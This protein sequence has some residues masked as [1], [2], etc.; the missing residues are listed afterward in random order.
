MILRST[1][2]AIRGATPTSRTERAWLTALNAF[3]QNGA[4]VLVG[5]V[6]TPIV[7][8]LLGS[9]LYGNWLIIVQMAGYLLLADLN[10][11]T[12]LKLTLAT[13]QHLEDQDTKRRQIGASLVVGLINLPLYLIGGIALIWAAPF[14][15]RDSSGDI[16]PMRCALGLL[17]LNGYLSN[18]LGAPGVVLRGMNLDFK[19]MGLKAGLLIG[20]GL[21][22]I[23]VVKA[24]LG[25]PGLA[26]NRIVSAA[27]M[28]GLLCVVARRALPWFGTS[29]PKFREVRNLLGLSLWLELYSLAGLLNQSSDL[30]LIGWVLGP[31][32]AALFSLTRSLPRMASQP[33]NMLL[34]S[35]N[36]GL[37]DLYGRGE[38]E[39]IREVRLQIHSAAI[40]LLTVVSCVA[41]ALNPAFVHRWVGADK[42]AG[43]VVNMLLVLLAAQ[44]T[45]GRSDMTL[46]DACLAVRQ[47]MIL[48]VVSGVSSV[49]FGLIFMQRWGLAG[50]AGGFV[51]GQMTI[52]IVSPLLVQRVIGQPARRYWA[53]LAKPLFVAVI[54][55]VSAAVVG[56]NIVELSWL[57]LGAG[58]VAIALVG[59]VVMW[60]LGLDR[61]RRM[62][63]IQRLPSALRGLPGSR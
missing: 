32:A 37:G 6:V 53:A 4:R 39:Q 49:V 26:V 33:L 58:G 43:Y 23:A 29:R 60:R 35:V 41:L 12:G 1:L 28:G 20:I 38:L 47:R 22:D 62:Q 46:L 21:L 56:L 25:L 24:G 40:V 63:M 42:F 11:G 16:T 52:T 27:L 55:C 50:L 9:E 34:G 7:V 19:A 5:L 3:L 31:A 51:L 61:A 30:I 45:L 44:M 10:P 14:L 57:Q 54:L 17:M 59:G 18:F 36:A 13:Q 15:I 2:R 8:R 48:Y